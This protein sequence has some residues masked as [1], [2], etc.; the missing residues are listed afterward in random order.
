MFSEVV[1]VSTIGLGLNGAETNC[2]ISHI[3][4]T[5]LIISYS[6]TDLTFVLAETS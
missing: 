1:N 6:L 5:L 3:L 2:K 4:G